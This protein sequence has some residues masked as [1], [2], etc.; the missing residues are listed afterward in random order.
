M[1]EHEPE[2]PPR[3]RIEPMDP[4]A[5]FRRVLD[6]LTSR[7]YVTQ[8]LIAINVLVFG[9]MVVRGVSPMSPLVKDLIAWGADYGPR[10]TGGEPW[11]LFTAMFLHIGVIHIAMNMYVLWQI[12]RFVERI[13]GNAGFLVLYIVAGLAGSVVSVL[14]K[15]YT[16][17][18][19]ASGAIFGLYGALFAFVIDKK[20]TIPREVLQSLQRNAVMFVGFNLLYGFSQKN[21]D[22]GAHLGG[23]A[24]GFLSGLVLRQPLTEEAA[25]GRIWR[26]AVLLAAGAAL[27]GLVVVA[28][29]RSFDIEGAIERFS[30]VE[31]RSLAAFNDVIKKA[32]AGSANDAELAEVIETKVLPDWRKAK[33]ELVAP[34]T[35]PAKESELL[36]KVLAYAN[37]RQEAWELLVQ[38]VHTGD[39]ALVK[40]AN[41]RQ[42]EAEELAKHLGD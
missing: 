40:R 31:E 42:R 12:G 35:L 37:A 9:A 8:A 18:A 20:S 5:E 38:A 11:R 22:M 36:A 17:S 1:S 10:T 33:E 27:V 24:G 28:A 34:K 6:V 30:K 26:N 15:P 14:W 19:G 29:P 2:P 16:V 3:L 39:D 13:V 4:I 7:T 21:I 23:L 32:K 25:K 41:E